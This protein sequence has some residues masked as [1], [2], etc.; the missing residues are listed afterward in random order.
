MK[1]KELM[2]TLL[3]DLVFYVV[4]SSLLPSS[5]T[6]ATVIAILAPAIFW[7]AMY[8]ILARKRNRED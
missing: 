3:L 1:L 4:V 6:Y 7:F 2:L 5:T 8:N